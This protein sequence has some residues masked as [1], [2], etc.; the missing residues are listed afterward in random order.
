MCLCVRARV[1]VCMCE[2]DSTG[3][4]QVQDKQG[5]WQHVTRTEGAY[6]INIGDLMARWTNDRY[7]S[8]LHRV[9]NPPG[10]ENMASSKRRQSIAYFCNINGDYNVSTIPTCI[11]PSQPSKYQDITAWEHLT[12]KHSQATDTK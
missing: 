5:E 10:A 7:V 3:G 1:C 8:T 11:T 9:V 4:L 6:V 2:Q 12:G